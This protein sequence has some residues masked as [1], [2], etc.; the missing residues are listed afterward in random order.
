MLH[1]FFVCAFK[2]LM[3]CDKIQELHFMLLFKLLKSGIGRYCII[4]A[5]FL[6]AS[7]TAFSLVVFACLRLSICHDTN[8][9][10]RFWMD[11]LFF[12][13]LTSWIRKRCQWKHKCIQ[14]LLFWVKIGKHF[15]FSDSN[16]VASWLNY[17]EG[18][19]C[20]GGC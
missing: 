19:N 6:K 17:P 11:Y 3:V 16:F 8:L 18:G 12:A 4:I 20:G 14:K 10:F 2:M 9:Y 5:A 1:F 7:R 13:P 15:F